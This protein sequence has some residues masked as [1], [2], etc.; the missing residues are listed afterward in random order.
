MRWE[1]LSC[2]IYGGCTLKCGD[3]ESGWYLENVAGQILLDM[4]GLFLLDKQRVLAYFDMFPS[5]TRHF[6]LIWLR[7]CTSWYYV[8]CKSFHGG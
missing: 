3:L 5:L 8:L 1:G 2:L 6:G 4:F 7:I